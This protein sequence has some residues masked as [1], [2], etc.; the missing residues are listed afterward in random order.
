VDGDQWKALNEHIQT[1]NEAL[2]PEEEGVDESLFLAMAAQAKTGA[3]SK[4]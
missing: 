2:N 3:R 4:K 1:L